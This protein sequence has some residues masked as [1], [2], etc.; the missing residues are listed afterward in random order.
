MRLILTMLVAASLA[1]CAAPS[2]DV[3]K[4]G[5][6]VRMFG[7]AYL[8]RGDFTSALRELLKA[9]KINPDDHLVHYDLGKVYLQKGKPELA[10]ASFKKAIEI[11][12]EFSPARND[13]GLAYLSIKNWD[14]AISCFKEITGDLL[15]ATPHF[16][17]V[18]LGH[19]Y[20]NKKDY[21]TA[22]QYYL[23]ALDA[24]PKF[25]N[26]SLGLARVY[27]ETNRTADAV[28]LLE[29]A[30]QNAPNVAIVYLDLGKAYARIKEPDKALAALRKVG[31]LSPESVLAEQAQKEIEKISPR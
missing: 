12:P 29:K 23:Q 15:Y 3:V 17:L 11:K 20:F 19:A 22:I 2:Q 16:P 4:R 9:E 18:N 8:D 30:S 10:I 25:I 31:E 6:A 14:A 26:A 5:Q 13:L 24:E 28:K 1:A 27:L 7:E 21:D